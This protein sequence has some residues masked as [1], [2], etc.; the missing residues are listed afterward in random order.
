MNTSDIMVCVDCMTV[1]ETGEGT[2]D[3]DRTPWGLIEPPEQRHYAITD[4][5]DEFGTWPCD[6]CGST[7]AGER[8]GYSLVN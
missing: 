5:H 6:A 4:D 2:G 7:L 8:F 1:A 3:F